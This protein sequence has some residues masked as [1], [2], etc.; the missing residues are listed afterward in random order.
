MCKV[1]NK[2]QGH[3]QAFSEAWFDKNQRT[4]LL[5]LNS[6]YRLIRRWARG[7]ACIHE[8]DVVIGKEITQIGPNRFSFGDKVFLGTCREYRKHLSR[9]EARKSKKICA[10]TKC[11]GHFLRQRTTDF[12]THPKFA[13][14]LYFAFKPMWWAFHAWDWL[15][16]DR[17]VPR[18]SFGFSTLTQWPESIGTDNPIDGLVFRNSVSETW[19]TIIAGAGNGSYGGAYIGTSSY[20]LVGYTSASTSSHFSNLYRAIFCF[21]TSALTSGVTISAAVLSIYGT[22]KDD[23]LSSTPDVDIYTSTPASTSAI[24]NG[25]FSQIASTSQTGSPI[26]YANWGTVGYNDFTFNSTG[27]G[28]VSKTGISKFGARNTNHDVA[29]SSPTWVSS[30]ESILS[31]QYSGFTG[32]SRD[33]KLVV[34]YTSSTTFP[35]T[36]SVSVSSAAS[37]TSTVARTRLIPKTAVASVSNAVS[38]LAAVVRK[39]TFKRAAAAAVSRA[40]SR[41]ATAA[42]QRIIK[43]AASI[44]ASNAASRLAAVVRK[45]TFKRASAATTT[46]ASGRLATANRLAKYIRASAASVTNAASRFITA[47]QGKIYKFTASVITSNAAGRYATA[48]WRSVISRL[49]SVSTTNAAGRLTTVHRAMTFIRASAAS[50]TNGAARLATGV[51]KTTY[52]RASV[53]STTNAAGRLTVVARLA[54]YKRGLSAAVTNAASR[55]AT[56]LKAKIF[57]RLASVSVTNAAARLATVARWFIFKRSVSVA[58]TNAAG[59]LAKINL[60]LNGIRIGFWSKVA[61]ITGSWTKQGRVSGSWTK[62]PRVTGGWTKTPRKDS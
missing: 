2:N 4:L 23:G 49:A 37:R 43:L 7:V 56:A 61:R 5:F 19:A 54:T 59:R 21:D 10:L 52:K 60:F 9:E 14:R 50:V 41:A 55:L 30:Q 11:P 28:N 22:A 44:T 51:R 34:T 20:P 38:R 29:A 16:A 13:K 24:A 25:D 62:Q 32:T 57:G 17:F 31:C 40:A 18:W 45:A 42:K 12:R 39:I 1:A 26:T 15:V 48:L 33:P 8:Y 58:T 47:V 53:A 46:N 3:F 35:R 36:A 27:R 6:K